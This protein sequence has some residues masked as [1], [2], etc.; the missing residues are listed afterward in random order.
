M[1][2]TIG[3]RKLIKNDEGLQTN[4]KSKDYVKMN[5]SAVL[6]AAKDRYQQR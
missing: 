6:E 5:K 4:G 1:S 2:S 3:K